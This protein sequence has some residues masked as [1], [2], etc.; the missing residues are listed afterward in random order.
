MSERPSIRD[1]FVYS[2]KLYE[3]VRFQE[4]FKALYVIGD[5]L[6]SYDERALPL[7]EIQDR[8]YCRASRYNPHSHQ[9]GL[10]DLV[11]FSKDVLSALPPDHFQHPDYDPEKTVFKRQKLTGLYPVKKGTDGSV[12]LEG[13]EWLVKISRGQLEGTARVFFSEFDDYTGYFYLNT[14]QYW[15]QLYSYWEVEP[16]LKILPS[17]KEPS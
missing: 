16:I 8:V 7:Q 12:P 17:L 15:R 14:E 13:E 3:I 10:Y 5:A 1:R 2:G 11:R 4:H 9:E 6:D